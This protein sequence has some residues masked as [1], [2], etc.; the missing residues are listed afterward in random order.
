MTSE[1]KLPDL[2]ENIAAGDVVSI[3]V[4]VGET[5]AV[6]QPVLEIETDKA[7]V[8]VPSSVS[9]VVKEILVKAGEKATV[10]QTILTLEAG[11]DGPKTEAAPQPVPAAKSE[12]AP[13]AEPP[14]P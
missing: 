7:T 6:D 11:S 4:A 9:G 3:L 2:G 13:A 1:F 12:P 8:E 5:I 14:K 10:G